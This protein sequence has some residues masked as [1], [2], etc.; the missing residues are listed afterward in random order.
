MSETFAE[1]LDRLFMTITKPD[2]EEY[3]PEEIQA[4]TDKAITSSYIY[5][6]R[7]GKS[8]N[9]T[10]DKVKAL[11]DFF[12]IDPAYFLSDKKSEP[13]PDPERLVASVALRA[14]NIDLKTVEDML[15][16]IQSLREKESA[17][18]ESTEG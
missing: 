1:K 4:A 12:G 7:A 5:R 15:L 2:G 11:A 17:K 14:R 6:L 3:S 9:P 18:G 10:I 8:K 16:M 13:M